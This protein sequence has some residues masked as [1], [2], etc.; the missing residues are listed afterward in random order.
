MTDVV[1]DPITSGYNLTKVNAN[2]DK[3]EASING[4]LLNLAGGNNV[5]LQDL[6]MNSHGILNLGVNTG[7]PDSILTIGVADL[8]YYNVAGDTLTGPMNVNSQVI[9]GLVVP[10]DDT[11]PVRKA[12]LDDVI[13]AY[14]VGDASLQDQI[15]GINPPMGSAFSV[16]S[17]HD[18]V[19]TNSIN[20][21]ANKNAWSFG[22]VLS[23]VAGQS[24]TVGANSFWTIA[25]GKTAGAGA[26]TAV[27]ADP[28]DYG[29]LT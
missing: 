9:T 6:D 2:F 3:I 28:M 27:P 25:D 11:S 29:V 21:P 24:V 7:E 13:T 8:R 19:I 10:V 15:L 1:L 4:D 20:I 23:I 12:E 5:M 14:Q 16:I 26:L 22:P 18:Q 17:W